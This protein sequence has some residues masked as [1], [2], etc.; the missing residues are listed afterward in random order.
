MPGRKFD[1]AG[2]VNGTAIFSTNL[3]LSGK[4]TGTIRRWKITGGGVPVEIS[5]VIVPI[6]EEYP[7]TATGIAWQSFAMSAP[8]ENARFYTTVPALLWGTIYS[9]IVVKYGTADNVSVL[10]KFRGSFVQDDGS[11]GGGYFGNIIHGQV[12]AFDFNGKIYVGACGFSWSRYSYCWVAD[13]DIFPG[14]IGKNICY[15]SGEIPYTSGIGNGTSSITVSN[16]NNN[17]MMIYVYCG[18][19]R[20][21]LR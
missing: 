17:S 4:S 18:R 15:W 10:N 16:D 21:C 3:Y 11:A 6:G 9:G 2:D 7:A 1:I 5:S 13:D 14:V 8:E 19:R 12:S 20:S